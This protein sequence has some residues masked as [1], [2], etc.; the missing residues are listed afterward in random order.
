[1]LTS[2]ACEIRTA[3]GWHKK[4][5]HLPCTC[6]DGTSLL[7]HLGE[8]VRKERDAHSHGWFGCSGKGDNFSVC[9]VKSEIIS[10]FQ[11]CFLLAIFFLINFILSS[12][13]NLHV[14]SMNAIHMSL[15]FWAAFIFSIILTNNAQAK[16]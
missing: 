13:F 8:N 6:K 10:P 7:P 2:L 11:F 14:N 4:L 9:W 16:F 1:M 12:W 15:C 3:Y 5:G